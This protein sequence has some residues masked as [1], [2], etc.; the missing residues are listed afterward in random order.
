MLQGYGLKQSG[1]RIPAGVTFFSSS[2]TPAMWTTQLPIQWAPH[3]DSF[4][5][6]KRPRRD[7]GNSPPP[8]T[9]VKNEWSYTYINLPPRMPFWR[10]KG[11]LYFY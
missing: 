4:L 6:V 9:D 11:K 3:R 8:D 10:G 2:T 1:F 7:A 5:R